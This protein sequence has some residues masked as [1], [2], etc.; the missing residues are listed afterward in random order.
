MDQETTYKWIQE[1]LRELNSGT[2]S[3]A[4]RQR[5]VTIAENDPFVADALEGFHANPEINHN[6]SL[7]RITRQIKYTKRER[8]KWFMPNM[9]V[10]AIAASFL[11]ILATYG[12]IVQVQKLNEEAVF[13]SVTPDTLSTSDTVVN[14]IVMESEPAEETKAVLKD[15]PVES[16][17]RMESSE[18]SPVA[19]S[20]AKA[21]EA[22]PTPPIVESD[23]DVAA[24]SETYGTAQPGAAAS[25]PSSMDDGKSLAAD[26]AMKS[27]STM[28]GKK[29]DEGYFAN[30]MDPDMMRSRVTGRV[31]EAVSGDP[32][33]YAKLSVSYTNQLFYTNAQGQFELFIPEEEA[34]LNVTYTGLVDSTFIVK[35]GEENIEVA[36]NEG[37][38]IESAMNKETTNKGPVN[39]LSNPAIESYLNSNRYITTN[40]TLQLTPDPSSARRK[41]IVEF[42][43]KKDG[44]PSDIT[45][46]ESSRDKTYDGEATR[47]IKEGP[48][49]VCPGEQNSCTRRYTFY[50]R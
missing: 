42:K 6:D 46:I 13:V 1:R 45:V 10:T 32:L 50:F 38:I 21:K 47:L 33:I 28:S 31:V 20:A 4:D 16:P 14:D 37:A 41:V 43:I 17:A 49:W 34:V 48:E 36:L 8:R 12:V 2:L 35:Q 9:A 40:S 5:L 39:S 7:D 30:Q 24:R 23:E 15:T 11:V 44:R 26:R 29:Q 22:A 19:S 18:S 3:E 25:S 27:Q